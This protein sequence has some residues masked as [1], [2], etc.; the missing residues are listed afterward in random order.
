VLN[1]D[2]LY[3]VNLPPVHLLIVV[4]YLCAGI[5]FTNYFIEKFLI[6]RFKGIH[7]LITQFVVSVF[8]IIFLSVISVLLTSS[9]LGQPFSFIQK[10]VL[11][12][13]GFNF[14]INL[15]LNTVNAVYF[16]N[17][18]Y[19]EKE[20]EAEKLKTSTISARY[21]VLNN[22]I[23]THFLFNN[24]NTLSTLIKTN[25]D[26]ADVFLQKLSDIYRYVL[27][28][29]EEE[30]VELKDELNFLRDYIELL[31]IR[32]GKALKIKIDIDPEL[33]N[34]MIPP[35]VL[36]L[37][38]ENVV[39][40]N[41]FTEQQPIEVSINGKGGE[42]SVTNTLQ[43]KDSLETSFGIGLR[44][45][46]ERYGFFEKDIQVDNHAQDKFK[47]V[48]PVINISHEYSHS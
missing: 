38:L 13:A 44:N 2:R 41:F 40:H 1:G 6:N 20:L 8:A 12:T 22:Q 26:K 23:N 35:T 7:P 16:F 43:K 18:K 10:N 5:W 19:K 46:S 34:T 36:Q 15:F 33:Q 24:L 45:I 29:G 17:Q 3:A 42:I 48:V 30:L 21:E 11:L 39:K 25:A 27:K 14:R 9:Y 4:S 37:L 28:N 47:V 31:E 32:F